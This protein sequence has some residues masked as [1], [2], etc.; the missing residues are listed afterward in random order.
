VPNTC[1]MFS[2]TGALP[3]RASRSRILIDL[4]RLPHSAAERLASSL[5]SP[6]AGLDESLRPWERPAVLGGFTRA[7]RV[8]LEVLADVPKAQTQGGATRQACSPWS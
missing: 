7:L 5:S 8:H 2:S 1:P 3:V 4:A 6:L